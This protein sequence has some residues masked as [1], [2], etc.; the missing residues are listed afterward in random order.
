MTETT[1]ERRL[2]AARYLAGLLSPDDARRFEDAV[3]EHPSMAEELGLAEQLARVSRLLD[4]ERLGERP[5]WWHDRRVP[6]GAAVVIA[7]L[8]VA[9]AW[10]AVRAGI[11]EDR[12]ALLEARAAEGFLLPPSTTRTA[13]ADPDRGGRVA[14]GGRDVPERVE[15]RIPVRGKDFELF[16]IAIAREDGTAVLHAERLQRDSNGELR[17]ALNSS[18]LPAG[19]YVLRIEGYTWRGETVAVGHVGLSALG[20]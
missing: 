14:L 7:L 19:S 8:A 18:L 20:R 5:P 10:S 3:R 17:L 6:M 4:A 15:L 1:D 13:L 9:T 2:L 11:A 16:R 12:M